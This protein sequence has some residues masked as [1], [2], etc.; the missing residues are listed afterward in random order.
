MTY[1]KLSFDHLFAF[2][3][4]I[5]CSFL[6]GQK[7]CMDSYS[8]LAKCCLKYFKIEYSMSNQRTST[9]HVHFQFNEISKRRHYTPIKHLQIN[10]VCERS[11]PSQCC[12]LA[13]GWL[14]EKCH[15][16]CSC[17]IAAW[18]STP[19]QLNTYL[20]KSLLQ[21][22]INFFNYCSCKFTLFC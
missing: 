9:I 18:H 1:F 17:I 21:N 10:L 20:I 14:F 12:I 2:C 11:E 5:P 13:F 3:L 15:L 19:Q 6:W 16:M 7:S 4:N 22:Y 8:K